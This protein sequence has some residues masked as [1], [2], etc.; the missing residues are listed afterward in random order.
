MP[1]LL[2]GMEAWKKLSEGEIQ[3]HEKI[4]SKV[5]K[6]LFNLPITTPYIGIIIATGV[7]PEI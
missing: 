5:R 3:H 2:Y 7:Q 1:A 4:Q 6:R